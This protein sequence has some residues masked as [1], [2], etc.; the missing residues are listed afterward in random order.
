MEGWI[1]AGNDPGEDMRV[2]LERTADLERLDMVAWRAREAGLA[3]LTFVVPD[4]APEPWLPAVLAAA[5]RHRSGPLRILVGVE[6]RVTSGK[7]HLSLP[8]CPP[9]I[10]RLYA[11]LDRLPNAVSS[12]T[13]LELR[14]AF[15]DGRTSAHEIV[16]RTLEVLRAT[17]RRNPRVV[18]SRPFALLSAAGIPE[19]RVD[20]SALEDLAWDVVAA[21]A[22]I[23]VDEW[24]RTPRA[25]AVSVFAA[26]GVE[27]LCGTG[28]RDTEGVGVYDYVCRLMQR[29]PAFAEG[30]NARCAAQNGF[31]I[32]A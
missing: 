29:V 19:D 5:R 12:H 9:G 21:G 16:A 7:G 31:R 8:G 13:A 28:T 23:Q 26:A 20:E 6:A 3:A 11:T 18:L 2:P 30:V 32:R 22:S 25:G 27:L 10:D 17:V 4:R 1:S 14:E 15:E 24:E